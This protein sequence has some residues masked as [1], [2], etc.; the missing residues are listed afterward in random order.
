MSSASPPRGVSKT[1]S[2]DSQDSRHRTSDPAGAGSETPTSAPK[3][4][5]FDRLLAAQARQLK[6]KTSAS[7]SARSTEPHTIQAKPGRNPF[8]LPKR[9]QTNDAAGTAAGPSTFAVP[10]ARHTAAPASISTQVARTS[11][12]T[13]AGYNL[14]GGGVAASFM[15]GP[16]LDLIANSFPQTLLGRPVSAAVGS[17]VGAAVYMPNVDAKRAQVCTVLDPPKRQSLEK[18]ASMTDISE[19]TLAQRKAQGIAREKV[20]PERVHAAYDKQDKR[21]DV[22]ARFN[23]GQSSRAIAAATKVPR[24]VLAQWKAD[25]IAA[26][27]VDAEATCE[28]RRSYED[29]RKQAYALFEQDKK[30]S[31]S[32]V[33]RITGSSISAA[34]E[35]KRN[36]T[37]EKVSHPERS[38][39]RNFSRHENDGKKAEAYELLIQNQ[40]MIPKEA[41]ERLGV[42]EGTILRWKAK[43]L[44]AGT[45]PH[46]LDPNRFRTARDPEK[47]KEVESLLR[48]NFS[49]KQIQEFT[50]V[51]GSTV[52]RLKRK[53][54]AAAS[55]NPGESA[56]ARPAAFPAT[57]SKSSD[58]PEGSEASSDVLVYTPKNMLAHFDEVSSESS[59]WANGS[60]LLR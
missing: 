1:T 36:W 16:E 50:G 31:G 22:Y 40:N 25:G 29:K 15:R 47:I 44:A 45:L 46:G 55:V 57:A 30:I 41:A 20:D 10:A 9:P 32:E 7:E 60:A 53:E 12:T 8:P 33:S 56:S 52:K 5:R 13:N 14:G 23:A 2:L 11:G 24:G 43:D 34:N 59:A 58:T 54:K 18:I 17:D 37:G 42:T 21:D 27:R 3:E 48:R 49:N 39:S 26:G 35:W 51:S 28:G 6:S 38:G 4:T 19:Q